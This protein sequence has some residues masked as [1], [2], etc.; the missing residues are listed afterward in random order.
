MEH[1]KPLYSMPLQ[2]NFG[3][4]MVFVGKLQTWGMV[5]QKGL[6]CT[7]QQWRYNDLIDVH[8][9]GLSAAHKSVDKPMRTPVNPESRV[10]EGIEQAFIGSPQIHKYIIAT[11]EFLSFTYYSLYMRRGL[12]HGRHGRAAPQC[13][14]CPGVGRF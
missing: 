14:F 2:K 4:F 6:V 12:H 8:L 10:F 5:R 9:V 11:F 3:I 7:L 13:N 1:Y